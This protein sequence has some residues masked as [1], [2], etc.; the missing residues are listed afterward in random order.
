[1]PIILVVSEDH[2]RLI[3]YTPGPSLRDLLDAGDERVR[4]GCR[5]SGACGLCRVQ[6]LDGGAGGEAGHPHADAT[7]VPVNPPTR[8]ELASLTTEELQGGIRMACQVVPAGD[9]RVRVVN[10][11][12][13]SI[14]RRLISHETPREI[15]AARPVQGTPHSEGDAY[16]VAVDLG[17]TNIS[18]SLWDLKEG[19][20]VSGRFGP[21][22]QSRYGTD[23]VA[24]SGWRKR[25][26]GR[27]RN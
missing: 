1:M 20:R 25:S 8:N 4:S 3:P 2:E 23:V 13:K 26:S 6:I 12:P 27:G 15:S 24:A 21:N 11:A 7:R 18:L 17:T 22:G 5:G 9:I 10:R 19:R 16:G 14:W